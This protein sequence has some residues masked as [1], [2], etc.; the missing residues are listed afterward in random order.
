MPTKELEQANLEVLLTRWREYYELTKPGVVKL[1]VFTAMCR[2]CC[3]RRPGMLPPLDHACVCNGW[4][5]L[6]VGVRCGGEPCPRPAYRCADGSNPVAGRLPTGR[7]RP[8]CGTDLRVC[9][10]CMV[11]MVDSVGPGQPAYRGAD[12]RITHR[13]CGRVHRLPETGNARKTS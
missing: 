4:H 2:V 9:T 7:L 11:S 8:S 1:L 13:L 10:R 5:R 12:L 3:W 6:G